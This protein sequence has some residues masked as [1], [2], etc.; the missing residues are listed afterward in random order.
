MYARTRAFNKTCAVQTADENIIET[1]F[2]FFYDQ[3]SDGNTFTF[4]RVS[5]WSSTESNNVCSS[6]WSSKNAYR[7]RFNSGI[8]INRN[9]G[10]KR[11]IIIVITIS[12]RRK[13]F[14]HSACDF[15]VV[16]QKWHRLQF[17]QW[18]ESVWPESN[19]TFDER[20]LFIRKM[21]I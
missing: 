9:V 8:Q 5:I 18:A 12:E 19:K 11:F 2:F 17:K 4:L 1:D 20:W 15:Q 21:K 10:A 7:S 6:H 13:N 16:G 3:K 14:G